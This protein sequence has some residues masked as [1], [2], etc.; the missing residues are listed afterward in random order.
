M[1]VAPL[2]LLYHLPPAAF[3]HFS[4]PF[5][6]QAS[7]FSAPSTLVRLL[8]DTV[9]VPV[10]VSRQ[11]F[12]EKLSKWL[13]ATDA[14]A[15]HGTHQTLKAAARRSARGTSPHIS[16]E[17]EAL[18][19]RESAALVAWVS[20]PV[21]LPDMGYDGGPSPSQWPRSGKTAAAIDEF[22]FAPYR[23]HC[24]V[25]QRHMGLKIAALR[26]Q[27]RHLLDQ[28]PPPLQ[29]LAELDAVWESMLAAR[30]QKLLATVP[31][32]LEKRFEH[33]R[34][35]GD[36]A[37]YVPEQQAVLLAELNVRLLP[38]LGLVEAFAQQVNPYKLHA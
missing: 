20:G 35:A 21:R 23:Q 9:S 6:V 26:A 2:H 25:L 22:G 27:V 3:I 32:L 37:R 15:L 14:V 34:A 7:A 30:E 24:L 28:S 18:F 33:L 1:A 16:E 8:T 19:Q 10:D 36:L 11:D 29:I 13:G 4:I 38:T 17:P 12:A 5:T 31:V